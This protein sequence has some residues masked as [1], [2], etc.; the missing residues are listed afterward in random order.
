MLV[1]ATVGAPS[2]GITELTIADDCVVMAD[3]SW[4]AD[5]ITWFTED[6]GG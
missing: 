4:P 3:G 5:V 6:T 1:V 2:P